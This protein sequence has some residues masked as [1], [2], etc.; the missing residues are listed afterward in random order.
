[1]FRRGQ[2]N[3]KRPRLDGYELQGLIGEGGMGQVYRGRRLSDDRNV[4]IKFILPNFTGLTAHQ[5]TQRFLREISVCKGFNHPNVVL[6]LDGG[7]T[8]KN[9]PYMVLEYLEGCTLSEHVDFGAMSEQFCIDLL[10]QV[11]AAFAYYHPEGLIHRD[12]KPSNIFICKDGRVVLLD[13]GLVHADSRTRLTATNEAPGTL[14]TMAP[15][16][17]AGDELGPF[18]DIYQLGVS[19]YIAACNELPYKINDVVQFSLGENKARAPLVT[20]YKDVSPRFAQILDRCIC[21]APSLRYQ[22]A[23]E[24]LTALEESPR[25][26]TEQLDIDDETGKNEPVIERKASSRKGW[27]VFV[28]LFILC[29]AVLFTLNEVRSKKHDESSPDQERF[30]D[31]EVLTKELLSQQEMTDGDVEVLGNLIIAS[32][33]HDRLCLDERPNALALG[34]YQLARSARMAQKTTSAAVIY[35][36][37]ISRFGV[38]T[39][40]PSRSTLYEEALAITAKPMDLVDSLRLYMKKAPSSERAHLKVRLAQTLIKQY[41][42]MY[43]IHDYVGRDL[44]GLYELTPE[45]PSVAVEAASLVEKDVLL[46]VSDELVKERNFAYFDA[47]HIVVNEDAKDRALRAMEKLPFD[48]AEYLKEHFA[49]LSRALSLVG[50]LG[51]NYDEQRAKARC[52]RAYELVE[53]MITVCPHKKD[54]NLLRCLSIWFL[55]RLEEWEKAR[56]IL[57]TLQPNSF[58][59][60]ERW[61]YYWTKGK[62]MEMSGPKLNIKHFYREAMHTFKDPRIAY[63]F[64][65]RMTE[66]SIEGILSN[67]FRGLN[68]R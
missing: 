17:Y 41:E 12:I 42:H 60:D 57:E 28:A 44:Q 58:R 14:L 7:K 38:K 51:R 56:E 40:R 4:A 15:E 3:E 32:K 16:Q 39:I 5:V 31:V 33:A 11:S 9:I 55:Y 36:Q 67:K 29:I 25:D 54:K 59:Y 65:R 10:K 22:S 37:L 46:K 27:L 45:P 47:L 26:R 50:R 18:T 49:S 43:P 24:I 2:V 21:F 52:R 48:N 63:Y 8:E 13:F 23:E 20:E 35:G 34:F 61:R 6:V 19:L 66:T 62:S 68:T 30:A 53:K 64:R 1:M